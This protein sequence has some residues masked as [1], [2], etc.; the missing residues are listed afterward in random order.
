MNILDKIKSDDFLLSVGFEL[1][2]AALHKVLSRTSECAELVDAYKSGVLTDTT[3]RSFVQQLLK[4][5]RPAEKFPYDITL[6]LLAVSVESFSSR[7]A[8]EFIRDLSQL[9]LAELTS[10]IK[11]AK[12]CL[13]GRERLAKNEYRQFIFPSPPNNN[14][15]EV[16]R[17]PETVK[18]SHF[19]NKYSDLVT[20]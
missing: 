14:Y 7:F 4:N 15:R 9:D 16:H 20:A 18:D 2:P 12:L 19:E 10:C 6:A 17:V 3:L 11:V 13:A 1:P 5:F 8:E